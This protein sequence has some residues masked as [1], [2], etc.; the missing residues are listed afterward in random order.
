MTE[1]DR[2]PASRVLIVGVGGLGCPAAMTLAGAGVGTVGL[3]D[4]DVV[5]RSN[6]PRQVLYRDADVG[7]R[8]VT[9][10]AAHLRQLYPQ[11]HFRT[12]PDALTAANAAAI[13][14]EFDVVID[15]TDRVTAKYLVND[16]AVGAAVPFVHAGVVGFEGQMLA[17]VPR[18]TACLRCL[19]PIPPGE[20]DVPTC[21]ETG[22]LGPLA[23]VMGALQ[24]AAA[25][26]LLLG[27]PAGNR[28]LTYDAVRQRW[29]TIALA[30][31]P[32]CPLCG[33]AP[34]PPQPGPPAPTG[35]RG[36]R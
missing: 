25:L 21:Q 16:Q 12:F 33:D 17:V 11:T 27:K 30:R 10:A 9:A 6:L 28:L 31:N 1:T 8:K 32:A 19:F 36:A 20:G 4:G 3:M 2:L 15:G 26:R 24:A 29:R 18:Q 22:I 5:D 7:E 34:C 35:P 14:A 13:L 23:G